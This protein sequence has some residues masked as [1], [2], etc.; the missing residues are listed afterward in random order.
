M[1]TKAIKSIVSERESALREYALE[2]KREGFSFVAVFEKKKIVD[3]WIQ[4]QMKFERFLNQESALNRRDQLEEEGTLVKAII[5][6]LED[7]E[8][9][10]VLKKSLTT[11]DILQQYSFEKKRKAMLEFD[12]RYIES[13]ASVKVTNYNKG[14]GRVGLEDKYANRLES[15]DEVDNELKELNFS[16]GRVDKALELVRSENEVGCDAM[17]SKHLHNETYDALAVNFNYS[18]R[19]VIYKIRAAEELFENI[20]K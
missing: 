10:L 9:V 11:K 12:R 6:D 7:P 18:R 14:A 2:S 20:I 5:L 17:I 1:L 19:S 15:L 13:Q 3:G 16:I 4:K 8:T